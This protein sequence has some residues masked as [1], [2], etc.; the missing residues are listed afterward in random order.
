MRLVG[1]VERGGEI[2]TEER[3]AGLLREDP[4]APLGFGGEFTLEWDDCTCT[5]PLGVLGS[6]F[7]PGVISCGG[8]DRG[9]VAPEV[10][11]LDLEPALRDAVE[12]RRGGAVVALS[13]GVD[14][15][16]VAAFA[17]LPCV[18]V[19]MEDSLDFP[20]A[21]QVASALGVPHHRVVITPEEADRALPSVLQAIPR[22]SAL[23]VSIALTL[24]F[25]CQA[26]AEAGAR[27]VLCGQGADELFAGYARHRVSGDLAS[28]LRRDFSTLHAQA[29]RDQ[30]V[31]RLHGTLLSYPY[32]DPRV[33]RAAGRIPAGDLVAGG[34]GKQPLRALAARH[35]PAEVAARGKKAMQYGSGIWRHLRRRARENGYKRS[36]QGYLDWLSGS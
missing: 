31:S 27:R 28:D 21:E 8:R 17:G 22:R 9:R 16:L 4:L 25:V 1:W 2:L 19:G 11:D 35:L 10:A 29:V 15:A 14:S 30:A 18:T 26:V 13:G 23:D 24:F 36:V 34:V 33:V 3:V 12:L 5:D 6:P 7:P 20:W 32:L